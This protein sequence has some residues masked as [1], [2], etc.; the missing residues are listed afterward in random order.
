VVVL[1]VWAVAV[2]VAVLVAGIVGYGLVGQLRRLRR[3]L[4]IAAGD[5][6]P[7]VRAVVPPSSQGR[8][9]ATPG[10][11]EVDL[12]RFIRTRTGP[13]EPNKS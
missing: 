11:A 12:P 7:R 2:G 5:L 8:H 6:L 10:G 9:R 13:A 4:D 3:A 1:V